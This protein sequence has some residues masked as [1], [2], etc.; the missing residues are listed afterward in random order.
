MFKMNFKQEAS[1][2]DLNLSGTHK[3][4]PWIT[5]VYS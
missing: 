5:L 3:Y 1:M 2:T 4:S